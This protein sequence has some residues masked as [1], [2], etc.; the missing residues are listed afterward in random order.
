M[1]VSRRPVREVAAYGSAR[2]YITRQVGLGER[3]IE[4]LWARL[5]SRGRPPDSQELHG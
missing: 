4:Q 2:R 1:A 5:L 3:V